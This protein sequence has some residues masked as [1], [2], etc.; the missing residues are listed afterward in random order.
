MENSN[1][2]Q[3]LLN[4]IKIRFY[5]SINKLSNRIKCHHEGYNDVICNDTGLFM[6]AKCSSCGK[7]RYWKN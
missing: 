5:R 2:I 4:V 6:Y 3:N 1:P 7:K